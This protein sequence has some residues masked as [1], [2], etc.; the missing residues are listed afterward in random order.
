MLKLGKRLVL[1]G[2]LTLIACS[3]KSSDSCN[4]GD[5]DGVVGTGSSFT[6]LINVSDTEFAVGGIDSGSTEPN[7]PTQNLEPTTMTLT[8]TGTKPHDLKIAC[9]PSGLPASCPAMSCFPDN[10]NIPTLQP[11]ESKTVMFTTPAVEGDYPF[12]SD[13]DGDTTIEPDGG[14]AGLVGEFV[15]M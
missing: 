2:T 15:L 4:P 9:I 5:Q 8:N 6:V 7:V 14:V 12:T 1:L 10:A 3:S 13:L 11:G